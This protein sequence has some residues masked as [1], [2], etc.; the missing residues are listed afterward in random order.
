MGIERNEFIVRTNEEFTFSLCEHI[1][2]KVLTELTSH[3]V[4]SGSDVQV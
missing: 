1:N 3:W 4:L 2:V